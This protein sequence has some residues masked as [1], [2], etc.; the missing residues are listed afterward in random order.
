RNIKE[1]CE[2]L[3]AGICRIGESRVQEALDKHIALKSY[4]NN[5]A[6]P[7]EFHMVGHLQANK[8]KK[9]LDIFTMIESMDSLKLARKMNEVLKERKASCDVLLEVNS[10]GED[11]KFGVNKDEVESCLKGFCELEMRSRTYDDGASSGR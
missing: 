8:L 2:V 4:A 9:A 1:I 3:D 11:A 5:R 6:I 10:S 7:L